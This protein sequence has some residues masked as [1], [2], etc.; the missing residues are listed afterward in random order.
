MREIS[1]LGLQD[2]KRIELLHRLQ[3]EILDLVPWVLVLNY[4][5]IYGLSSKVDW[6]PFPNENRKMYDAKPR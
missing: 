6:K 2:P 4:Q 3:A 5:D 1:L